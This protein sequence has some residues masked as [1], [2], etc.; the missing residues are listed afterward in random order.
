ML[1][2]HRYIPQDLTTDTIVPILKNKAGDLTSVNNYRAIAFS[3]SVSKLLEV[4]LLKCVQSCDNQD[5]VHL[6]IWL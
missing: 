4:I 5:D 1:V 2:A 3:N 6:S